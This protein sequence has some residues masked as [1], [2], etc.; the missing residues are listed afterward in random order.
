M[1]RRRRFQCIILT[2]IIMAAAGAASGKERN[3]SLEAETGLGYDSNAFLAPENGYFDPFLNA[4]VQPEKRS[5]FF[6]PLAL[7]G[8]HALGPGDTR[9]LTTFSA[10]SRF[11][12]EGGELENAN[13][14][15]LNLA[16]GV[17]FRL[18][19]KG[20]LRDTFFIGPI[21][22]Y[23][24]EIY[25][26]PDTGEE[27][28][29]ATTAQS[30]ANRYV[31][32]RYGGAAELR[33]RTTPVRFALKATASQYEYDEVPLLDSL[34]HLYYRLGGEAEYDI[35]RT[36]ELNL[37]YSY[38]VRDWDTR[39]A[40]NLQG[41]LVNGTIRKYT[42]SEAGV[43]VQ[44]TLPKGW[45]FYLDYDR[46]W[47]SDEFAGYNDYTRNRYRLRSRYRFGGEALLSAAVTYWDRDYPRA[48]A[49]DDPAFPRKD[50][51]TWEGEARL[52]LPL[53]GAW[54]FW[55][56]YQFINQGTTDPRY[57][58]QRQLIALGINLEF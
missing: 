54:K 30:L 27:R 29:T 33:V 9:L 4:V 52:E 26:D 12:P 5:G 57:D 8:K 42:Y 1:G 40:R 47:R 55:S 21:L 43:T 50:Y 17:E 51:R 22:G 18:R 37:S 23:N 49:F 39:R 36:T 45:T 16:T 20:N 53:A 3:Y 46:I 24:K 14:H 13:A 32:Y 10:A 28:A 35:F 58:Y 31:Y 48:F 19:S 2:V 7:K 44:Q 11:Y 38:Y 41:N 15:R 25:F 56:E 34:D 6:I